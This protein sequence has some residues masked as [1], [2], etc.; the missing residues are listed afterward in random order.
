MR[1]VLICLFSVCIMAQSPVRKISD[2]EVQRVHKSALL[3]DTHNDIPNE[4]AGE[5]R[6]GP[7]FDIGLSAPQAHTDLARLKQG[8]VGAVFFVSYVDGKYAGNGAYARGM[9]FVDSI[10]HD[11]VERYPN[12]FA[13]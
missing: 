4:Q 8:G 1:P 6:E 12:D 9:A 2:A 13:F 7:G 11:L 5:D 3:I 10:H